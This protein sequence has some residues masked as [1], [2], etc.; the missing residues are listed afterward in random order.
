M[1]ICSNSISEQTS[2]RHRMLFCFCGKLHLPVT[3]LSG[4][5]TR[6][7]VFRQERGM[8]IKHRKRRESSNFLLL[9]IIG[10]LG[11]HR[12]RQRNCD[13]AQQKESRDGASENNL[14]T[15][16]WKL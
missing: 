1:A 3:E 7:K 11:R 12:H 15:Q 16:I 2:D 14:W 5:E 10:P 9:V 13:S 8:I 6:G 4:G